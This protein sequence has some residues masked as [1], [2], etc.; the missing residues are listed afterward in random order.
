MSVRNAFQDDAE[1]DNLLVPLALGVLALVLPLQRALDAL[2]ESVPNKIEGDEAPACSA[3]RHGVL[4]LLAVSL[5]VQRL[6]DRLPDPA[7]T[8]REPVMPP[9]LL[10]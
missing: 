10:R 2:P 1:R 5:R 9:G 8:A 3:I 4:G 6:I 7:V